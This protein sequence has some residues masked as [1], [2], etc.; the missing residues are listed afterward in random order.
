MLLLIKRPRDDV[1]YATALYKLTYLLTYKWFGVSEH[2]LAIAQNSESM[3]SVIL[4]LLEY[5]KLKVRRSS[6]NFVRTSVQNH[7]YCHSNS[8]YW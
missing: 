2:L 8:L 4:I 7:Y 1:C 6:E 3:T 5:L